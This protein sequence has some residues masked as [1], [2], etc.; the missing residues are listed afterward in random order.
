M[1]HTGSFNV[2]RSKSMLK[3]SLVI[4]ICMFH[5]IA[6]ASFSETGVEGSGGSG[7]A[8]SGS[9]G[10]AS[11]SGSGSG[12]SSD[13][14]QQSQVSSSKPSPNILASDVIGPLLL[15]VGIPSAYIDRPPTVSYKC[16]YLLIHICLFV[17]VL[18]TL[19]KQWFRRSRCICSI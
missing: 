19:D 6:Y 18:L 7:G 8:G 10:A 2:L 12:G 1:L 4:P 11:S 14:V 3:A 16:L 17:A 15:E 13:V 5:H 9:S